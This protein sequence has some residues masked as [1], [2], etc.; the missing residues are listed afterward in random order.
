LAKASLA[1][2]INERLKNPKLKQGTIAALP[3]RPASQRFRREKDT[4][5]LIPARFLS[6][7]AFYVRYRTF[8]HNKQADDVIIGGL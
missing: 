8:R 7:A 2:A 1:L 6:R 4:V 3:R 5:T